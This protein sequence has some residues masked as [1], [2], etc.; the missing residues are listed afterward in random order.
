M[1]VRMATC[2]GEDRIAVEMDAGLGDG[3][4]IKEIG[5]EG[6]RRRDSQVWRST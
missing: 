4:A 1:L 3:G 2:E 6:A 5:A